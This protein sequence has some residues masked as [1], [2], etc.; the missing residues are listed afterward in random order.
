MTKPTSA[1]PFG[2]AGAKLGE[3]GALRLAYGLHGKDPSP[4]YK[5]CPSCAGGGQG[6][7]TTL[8][9]VPCSACAGTGEVKVPLSERS[10]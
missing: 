10:W 1:F 6:L 3:D 7:S 5:A 4:G 2:V 9:P 8:T